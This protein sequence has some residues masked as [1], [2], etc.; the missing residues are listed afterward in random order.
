MRQAPPS[1]ARRSLAS[2]HQIQSAIVAYLD[3][4]LPP[5]VRVVGVSN[6][7]RSRVMGGREKARGMRRGFPDLMLTGRYHALLEV[8]RKGGTLR[9]EQTEWRDWAVDNGVAYAVVRSIED[10]RAA[11]ASWRIVTREFTGEKMS[12]D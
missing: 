9:R 11:L 1:P 6:N 10:V 12:A 3:A 8:K 4:V 2:E 5:G 7:P